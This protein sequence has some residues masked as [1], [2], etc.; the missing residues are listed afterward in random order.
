MLQTIESD[1][2]DGSREPVLCLL[3]ST[4][5]GKSTLCNLIQGKD[6]RLAKKDFICSDAD[7]KSCTSKI[8]VVKNLDWYDK[9]GKL[10]LI[11]CPGMD[12][13]DGK[14]QEYLNAMVPEFH[15][16]ELIDAFLMI[17]SGDRL[18]NHNL[19]T[20]MKIY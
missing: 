14:D 1:K 8:T 7:D 20:N 13:V 5:S 9:S 4:G 12:D 19:M 15:K 11:D 6:P 3:G 16:L 2:L 17:M 18:G 10:T